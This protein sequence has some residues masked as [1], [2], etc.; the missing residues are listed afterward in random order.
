MEHTNPHGAARAAAD[1]GFSSKNLSA[2]PI[3]DLQSPEIR[4]LA[5]DLRRSHP[6]DRGYVQAA[7]QHLSDANMQT[8]YSIDDD[9]PASVTLRENKGSCGQR[10]AA[11]EALARV[12][13][14]ATRVRALW[15]GKR[16]WYHRLPLL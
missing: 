6:D 9:Q 16:F 4:A 13:G 15:Q 11:L 2:T 8:V 10:M 14:I 3:Y 7:H 5:T 1:A 12:A